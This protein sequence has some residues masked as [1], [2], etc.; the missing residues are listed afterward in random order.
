MGPVMLSMMAMLWSASI[1]LQTIAEIFTSL[2][3]PISKGG[4]YNAYDALMPLLRKEAARIHGEIF[5]PGEGGGKPT[6]NYD[7]THH[8]MRGKLIYVWICIA[9][10]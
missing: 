2:G 6:V 3:M 5:R 1:P 10:T 9:R 8:D 4:V 7:E